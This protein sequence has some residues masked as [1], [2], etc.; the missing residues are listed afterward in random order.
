MKHSAVRLSGEWPSGVWPS[1]V[2]PSRMCPSE[3]YPSGVQPWSAPTVSQIFLYNQGEQCKGSGYS[4]FVHNIYSGDQVF[5][6]SCRDT[7]L[8]LS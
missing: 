4:I 8:N 2:W 6:I 3:M 5:V 1:G 7:F